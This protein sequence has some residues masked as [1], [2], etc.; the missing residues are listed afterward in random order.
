MTVLDQIVLRR[1]E[2]IEA[3]SLSVPLELLKE[4]AARRPRALPVLDRLSAVR[5]ERRALIAEIK[6]KSPSKGELSPSL[7]AGKLARA[8]EMGGAFAVSCLVEPDYFGGGL[9]DLDAARNAI[10]IP[11]LYKDF[12]IDP[13]QVW[14]A[15]AHGA[16]MVLLIVALLGEK[17]GNY[18]AIA[19]EAGIQAL[20]EV[21]DEKEAEAAVRAGATLIGV[22]NRDLKTFAVDLGVSERII[23]SLPHGVTAVAESGIFT[24][25]DAA[26]LEEAGAAAFLVGESLVKSG[27]PEG[28]VRKLSER[29]APCLP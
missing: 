10:S 21:H 28:A 9:K 14:Q 11:L 6:R 17:V 23:P 7:D 26:R 12:V 25:A 27:D 15:R 19:E 2:R 16:D 13:Y 5:R 8:Y 18:L 4:E 29:G 3:E 20:V 24:T 22:N 1:R